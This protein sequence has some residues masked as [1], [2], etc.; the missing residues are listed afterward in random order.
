[1]VSKNQTSRYRALRH[2]GDWNFSPLLTSNCY[3]YIIVLSCKHPT[4]N[5]S[6]AYNS[7][8][9]FSPLIKLILHHAPACCMLMSI[10]GHRH[11]SYSNNAINRVIMVNMHAA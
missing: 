8:M 4:T 6:V 11:V 1:M 5:L 10:T 3:N 9:L 7:P 2:V